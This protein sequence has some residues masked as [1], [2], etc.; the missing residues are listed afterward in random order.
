VAENN[1]FVED[2][3]AEGAFP[4]RHAERLSRIASCFDSSIRAKADGRSADAKDFDA[5]VELGISPASRPEF[6]VEGGDAEQARAVICNLVGHCFYVEEQMA[7][8]GGKTA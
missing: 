2:D 1:F 3:L 7:K 8:E 6:E 4:L 5:V